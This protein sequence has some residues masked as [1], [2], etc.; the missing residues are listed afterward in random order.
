MIFLKVKNGV[1]EYINYVPFDPIR[2]LGKTEEE[3]LKVGYLVN[4][5]P[6]PVRAKD[7]EPVLKHDEVKGLYYEYVDRPLSKEEKIEQQVRD[8]EDIVMML[9]M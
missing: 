8:L 1:V 2:G 4:S 3:L 7:K 6:D 5:I 9:T